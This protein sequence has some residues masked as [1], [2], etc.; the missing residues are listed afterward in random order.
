MNECLKR[1]RTRLHNDLHA[2]IDRIEYKLNLLVGEHKPQSQTDTCGLR[3]QPNVFH[4]IAKIENALTDELSK[5]LFWAL[6]R[7]SI[8]EDFGYLYEVIVPMKREDSPEDLL[9][10]LKRNQEKQVDKLVF[11]GTDYVYF[12]KF[13]NN[14]AI[15]LGIHIEAICKNDGTEEN[16]PSLGLPV[17]TEKELVA[18]YLDAK[19]IITSANISLAR[20]HL[21]H[22]LGFKEEQLYRPAT[23]FGSAYFE[24]NFIFPQKQ[25]IFVDGGSLNLENAFD[26]VQW[27]D[28]NY[29]HIYAFEPDKKNF[30]ACE[31]VL[32]NT[33]SLDRSRISLYPEGLWN[34]RKVLSFH[35]TGGGGASLS[36]EGNVRIPV[37]SLDAVLAGRKV[38]YIKL[39]IE[40]AEKEA[41]EGAKET[42][43]KYKP[44][45][46][47]CLYHKFEDV[48]EVPLHILRL[49]P[50]YKMYIRHY[51]T[52]HY[53]TVLYCV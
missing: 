34:S 38:T 10:L 15:H 17:I 21:L 33:A 46:A 23:G 26:F 35:E 45:L 30:Q 20:D 44:K 25:E 5:D 49:V 31:E 50:S 3:I 36:M 8:S 19:I 18:Q 37:T 7:S 4:D 12:S 1:M 11:Y 29:E 53:E 27:C 40:G 14:A 16:G 41:L 43:C 24:K 52:F 6:C 48:I 13:I 42:I 22:V 32:C 39:D 51:S 9:S 28:G 47:I 2:K